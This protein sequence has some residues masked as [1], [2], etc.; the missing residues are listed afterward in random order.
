MV[1][2]L[3]RLRSSSALAWVMY[4]LTIFLLVWGLVSNSMESGYRWHWY[5]VTQYL[6]L[7]GDEGL[8][9]GVLL[10]GLGVT[11]QISVISLVFSSLIGLLMAILKLSG[12]VIG[13]WISGVFIESIRN[14]PLLIQILFIYFVIAPVLGLGA[15]ESAVISLSMF[16]GAYA[17]EM[18]RGG[19]MAVPK[20]QW[21]AAASLGMSR[22]QTQLFIILPQAFRIMIPPLTGQGISLIK[23][24]ALV[25]VIAIYDLT[26]QGQAVVAETFLTFEI[27]F[28]VAA[29]YLTLTLTLSALVQLLDRKITIR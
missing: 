29:L 23:D 11:L 1:R 25:S 2:F 22:I 13:R 21:E 4:L 5:R 16:E 8:V 27:W 14:T 20:G 12:S 18:I 10:K 9:P 19:I 3:G 7:T 6:F 26:M 24:S 28:T 15:F 17:S